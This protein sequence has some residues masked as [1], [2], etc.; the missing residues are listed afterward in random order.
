MAKL[1]PMKMKV[2]DVI[3]K[4]K[5]TKFDGVKETHYPVMVNKAEMGALNAMK[6]DIHERKPGGFVDRMVK[7]GL[8]DDTYIM[9]GTE[10]RAVA[11]PM[12]VFDKEVEK[13]YSDPSAAA[14][15]HS[16]RAFESAK[17]GV[18]Y[19]TGR[20]LFGDSGGGGGGGQ[21]GGSPGFDSRYSQLQKEYDK[22]KSGEQGRLDEAKKTALQEQRDSDRQKYVDKYDAY[23]DRFGKLGDQFDLS[24]ERSAMQGL[25]GEAKSLGDRYTGQMSGL[26]GRVGGYEGDV[27]GLRSGVDALREQQAGIG[28][29]I[30][31][32][33]QQAMDPA[34]GDMYNRN[35]KMLA[36]VAEQQIGRA[37]V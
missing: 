17:Q 11:A 32:M 18:D 31:G 6:K 34:S 28:K 24:Q 4:S 9:K 26:A 14:K 33:A 16:D 21:S 36:G 2:R 25:A 22:Y 29:Q 27:A 13:E 3:A 10:P 19:V 7:K 12:A 15:V 20:S 37:H 8:N 1:S 35:R 5:G 30:G 23:S